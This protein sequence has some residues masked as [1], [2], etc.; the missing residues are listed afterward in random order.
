[1]TT[2]NKVV[3]TGIGLI[4][5]LGEG[6]DAHW[7]ALSEAAAPK[8]DEARFAPYPVH[9]LA[10]LDWASQI[11]KK[12]DQRQMEP[13][14]RIG[15]YA[16]GAA[17]ADAGIAHHAELLDRTNLI[18]A[19]GSGERDTNVD[20]KVLEKA[21]GRPDATE[22]LANEILPGALRPTLFL[23]QLS[24]LLAGNISIV[25]NVTGASRTYMGEEMAGMGAIDDAFRRIRAG[26]GDLFLV[27]AAN[28]AER[29]D[30]I[31]GFELARALRPGP[32]QPVWSRTAAG[33][34]GMVLGSQGVFLVL[35]SEAHARARDARVYAELKA[36]ATGH[37]RRQ[38]GSVRASLEALAADIMPDKGLPKLGISAA[39]G[40]DPATAE[41]AA[42][43]ADHGV[44]ARAIAN[45]LGSGIEAALPAAIAAAALAC[46]K[47]AFYPPTE[48]HAIEDTPAKAHGLVLATAVGHWRGEA[49]AIL[50]PAD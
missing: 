15:V 11:P 34:G 25:H 31:L 9:P 23:A 49:L 50:S 7:A 2:Q 47:G 16:A 48:A 42:F 13:W 10:A 35:E 46:F 32:Y 37:Q 39:S 28:N 4:S 18:V 12:S 45:R 3:I 44:A 22:L 36:V 26:Q 43:L 1:M 21:A 38:A 20:Q 5:S 6:V 41:E 30:L 29:E 8:I 14:Q 27:G 19:A 24:N 33:Q 40:C 17:L